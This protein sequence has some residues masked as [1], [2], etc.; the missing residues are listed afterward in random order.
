MSDDQI[1]TIL[2]SLAVLQVGQARLEEKV[3]RINADN[4]RGEA[5]HIAHEERIRALEV[6]KGEVDGVGLER[7]VRA[8]EL[9]EGEGR[10]MWKLLT[11]GGVIG[12]ALVAAALKVLGG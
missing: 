11:A 10:G 7:R 5:V 9:S 4:T 12:A 6:A 8:L 1:R 3:D 2:A